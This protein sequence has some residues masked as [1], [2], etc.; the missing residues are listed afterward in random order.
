MEEEL[1]VA[2]AVT[3]GGGVIAQWLA[4]RFGFPSVLALLATGILAGP[5]TGLI[6]PR[7]M[8]GELLFPAVSI[9]VGIILF[10]GG[11][12][13]RVADVHTLGRPVAGL[14][15]IGLLVTW[16][17]GGL[18]ALA[19]FDLSANVSFLLGALLVVSGPTVVLPILDQVQVRDPV[20]SVLSWECIFIDPVGAVLAVVVF[21]TI[22]HEAETVADA[23]TTIAVSALV[24]IAVGVAAGFA[25]VVLLGR[26]L[27][28][29]R[30]HNPVSLASVVLC[31]VGANLVSVEAGLFATTCMGL[32]VANQRIAPVGHIAAFGEDIGVLLLGSLFIVLGAGLDPEAMGRVALPAAGLLLVLL[33]AR[34]VAVFLSTWRS[35]LTLRDKVFLSLIAPRGVVA[36]SVAS[37]FAIG[38]EEQGVTGTEDFAP[39]VFFVV[40]GSVLVAALVSAPA[41]KR[42]RLRVAPDR[43]IVLAGD[44][45]WVG[46]LAERLTDE[47]IPVLVVSPE[48]AYD[49]D[50]RGLLVYQGALTDQTLDEALDG[51][52]V[53]VALVAVSSEAANDYLVERLSHRLGR[54]HVYVV[55]PTAAAGE[56]VTDK[57]AWGRRAFHQGATR[58]TI[59]EQADRWE[60]HKVPADQLRDGEPTQ[61]PLI[62]IDADG[63]PAVIVDGK[64]PR[65]R[66]GYAIVAEPQPA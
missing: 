45:P 34:P 42:L 63:L 58:G 64:L 28:P 37:L 61:V 57:R 36:A 56:L 26:H 50:E 53:A 59:L 41:A 21:E 33:A 16:L 46:D 3:I 38:L 55:P 49:A 17:A 14:L 11:S 54:K 24:G 66:T 8:L 1:T 6:D 30:L 7:E 40:I 12:R 22:R 39:A 2:I 13:L 62:L 44:D 60:F 35:G 29:D 51:V 43:G 9:A 65:T 20:R 31:F 27:V 5:V 23:A 10:E 19:F 4:S 52:G 32:V 25:L 48:R 15:T 18:G 47:G